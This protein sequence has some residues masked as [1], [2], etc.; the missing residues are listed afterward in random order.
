[1]SESDPSETGSAEESLSLTAKS[2]PAAVRQDQTARLR[3]RGDAPR[4][5]RLSRKALLVLGGGGA[6]VI[7]GALI[8]ALQP[9]GDAR[10][11]WEFLY[12]LTANVTDSNGFNSIEGLF[13][14]MAQDVPAFKKARLK[15]AN[16]GDTG[17]SV[18]I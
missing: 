5:M 1:M 11:E 8:Y 6:L 9:P 7:G 10:P 18:E 2:E 4:V 12:E 15:W 14:Q 13:N 16:L 17:I 3:L